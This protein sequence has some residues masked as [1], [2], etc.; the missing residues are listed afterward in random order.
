MTKPATILRRTFL[1]GKRAYPLGLLVIT[2][3]A[4]GVRLYQLGAQ[5]LWYDEGVTA[6][7]AQRTLAELTQWTARDIQPPLYYY[8]VWGWGRVAG[9]SEWSLRFP[10]AF[11]GV[12]ATPLLAMIAQRLTGCRWISLLAALLVATHPLLVYYSQEARMYTMLVTLTLL[13]GYGLLRLGDSDQTKWR[14][15]LGYGL[16]ASM[17]LYT[18]YFAFF[19]LLALGIAFLLEHFARQK[20]AVAIRTPRLLGFAVTHLLIALGYLAWIGPVFQQLS[21]DTSYWQ[22]RLKLWEALRSVAFRFTSGETVLEATGKPLLFAHVLLTLFLLGVVGW[23]AR[24]QPPIRRTLLYVLCWLAI[25][26]AGVLGL[27]AFVPKFNARYVLIALPG[28]LL[29]WSSGI[30]LL[31]RQRSVPVIGRVLGVLC[32]LLIIASFG[33]ANRNWFVDPAFT[34]AQWREVAT[35]VRTHAQP[36]EAVVLVSGHSWP[37][38]DYYA[39][40][41]PAIRL[42]DL[43]ILDVNAVLDFANTGDVLRTRLAHKKGVWLVNWQADVVDPNGIAVRQLL[44]AATEA[45]VKTEFWQV[46]LRHFVDLEPTAIL[47]TPPIDNVLAANFGNQLQLQGYSVAPDGDLLLFWQLG[48]DS[49]TPLPDLYINLRTVTVTHLLYADPDDRRP[50]DYGFPV[51][52]WQPGQLV[53]GRIAATEW[54]GA[55]ALPGV[56]QVQLGVYDPAGD[57]AGLDLLDPASNPIGKFALL[58]VNLPH[59]TPANEEQIPA[60]S[61][62]IT[63]GLRV[64]F[65]AE[66]LAAE[67]GQTVALALHWF[68]EDPLHALPDLRL[69]WHT[70]PDTAPVASAVLPM[71]ATVPMTAWPVEHWVRQIVALQ[72]PLT[73]PAGAYVLSLI[74]IDD[75]TIAAQ[76]PFTILPSSRNFTAPPLAVTYEEDFGQAGENASQVRFLGLSH[77]IPATVTVATPLSLGLAWQSTAAVAPPADYVVTLQLWGADGRPVAQVDQPLPGGSATW[78][79]GQ[80]EVQA[81]TLPIPPEPGDYR[82][83]L[84]LYHPTPD[85]FP[86]LLTATGDDFLLLGDITV[87]P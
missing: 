57:A 71:Q 78:L 13:A 1:T 55:G 41:L 43:E 25:P 40:D 30:G 15:W 64:A 35:Y 80:V 21:S 58:T 77:A 28:L 51:M 70:A 36:D 23:H 42:P 2:L 46:Q 50:A 67:P 6:T 4:L 65:A 63:S 19:L 5:S 74:A 82:L 44:R 31:L 10:A 37:I 56:Y 29:L 7:L 85:G 68:L 20:F 86:R 14:A 38:W 76:R 66:P 3:L 47:S 39:S 9:W 8:V 61:A 62:E 22:G 73:L 87:T 26:L 52:R 32:G 54:A 81:L 60:D 11:W 83:I 69:A 75:G 16:S 12:L 34:K 27:A 17:A 84:A 24:T 49:P 18:H 33:I 45:P 53:M 48:T 72:P 79:P 59:A